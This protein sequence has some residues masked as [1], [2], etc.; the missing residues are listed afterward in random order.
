MGNILI[1]LND[2]PKEAKLIGEILISYG[3][4]ENSLLDLVD[5]VLDDDT[6]TAVRALFRLRSEGQ[7]L[8]VADAIT[9][10]WMTAKGLGGV[11]GLGLGAIRTCK[12]IRNQYAHST[13]YSRDGNLFFINLEETA[14]SP[15]GECRVT[16]RRVDLPLLQKQ[17]GFFDYTE[18]L[19]IFVAESYRRKM[20]KSAIRGE[21]QPKR[22]PTPELHLK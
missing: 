8:D 14:K 9:R 19:L 5:A 1:F 15:E 17:R 11:Y 16:P 12:S 22:I 4:L 6:D 21:F 7:R 2:H 18:D 10:K 20:G 3:E 13:W